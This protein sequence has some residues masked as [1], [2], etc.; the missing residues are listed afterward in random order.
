MQKKKWDFN[1]EEASWDKNPGRVKLAN[2]IADAI[3]EEVTLTS[4][5]DALDFGCG[6]GL[7][8][9]RLQPL[10]HS[11]TGVDSS[12]GMLDILNAKIEEGKLANIATRLLDLEKGDVLEG[13]YQL[14]L[15]SMTFHHVRN[16]RP[17]L[18]RF[19]KVAAPGGLLCIADL[20]PDEGR[21]HG[22]NDTVFHPGFDRTALTGILQEAGFE[23][24][25]TRTAATVTKRAPEGEKMDFTVFLMIGRKKM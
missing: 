20:D 10:V 22:E 7:L 16:I 19:H 25:R 24:V 21:F 18:D 17:L 1:E 9:L 8:T 6:T 12:E 2:D 13:E 14:I 5:M 11:V 23:D 4:E 15:S 3:N